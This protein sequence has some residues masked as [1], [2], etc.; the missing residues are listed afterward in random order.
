MSSQLKMHLLSR[1]DLTAHHIRF[2]LTL[3]PH[4]QEV[5]VHVHVSKTCDLAECAPAKHAKPGRLI[6][7]GG[8]TDTRNRMQSKYYTLLEELHYGELNPKFL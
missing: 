3:S 4:L 2:F 6:L 7:Q 8:L 1:S 5:R